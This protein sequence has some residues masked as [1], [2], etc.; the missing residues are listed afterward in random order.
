M[1]NQGYKSII[2]FAIVS[3]LICY[4]C[5]SNDERFY[6]EKFYRVNGSVMTID[7]LNCLYGKHGE[8]IGCRKNNIGM[9][10]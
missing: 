9:F 6:Y 10:L 1:I 4:L 5:K 8:H 2:L 7:D 3:L